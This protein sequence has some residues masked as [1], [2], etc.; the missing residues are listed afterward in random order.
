MQRFLHLMTVTIH[1]RGYYTYMHCMLLNC[2]HSWRHQ[3]ASLIGCVLSL[4]GNAR[5]RWSRARYFT[6][7]R[8]GHDLRSRIITEV[9]VRVWCLRG[10]GSARSG[11]TWS[12]RRP[13]AVTSVGGGAECRTVRPHRPVPGAFQH[14]STS[15]GADL[16]SSCRRFR[17]NLL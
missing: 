10:P 1:R 7:S 4:R 9:C 8:R 12:S 5:R 16:I 6:R 3:N 13:L 15:R 14:R 11:V 2:R 17:L